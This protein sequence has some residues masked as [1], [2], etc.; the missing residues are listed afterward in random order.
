MTRSNGV[1][2][3]RKPSIV[4]GILILFL[5]TALLLSGC[6]SNAAGSGAKDATGKNTVNVK[7]RIADT[8]TNPTFRVAIAKGFFENRGIDAESITFGSPAEGVNALF[9]KQV[10]IAYGADFPVLNALSKGEYSVIASAGQTTDEAA[11]MEAVCKEGYSEWSG[12]EG[13]E[14]EFH[15]RHIYSVSMG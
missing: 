1:Y 13:Q 7:I 5:A 14:S 6:S 3:V 8:S 2:I 15:S 12:F 9:I 10:D 4:T 11:A